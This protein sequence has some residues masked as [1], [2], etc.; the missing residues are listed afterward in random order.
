MGRQQ[1]CM[2]AHLYNPLLHLIK[3]AATYEEGKKL[4]EDE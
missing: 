3:C 1:A 2:N 4:K